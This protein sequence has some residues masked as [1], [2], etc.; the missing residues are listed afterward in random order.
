MRA[1]DAFC[2]MLGLSNKH[3]THILNSSPPG[4]DGRHFADDIF[5]RIFRK[6]KVLDSLIARFMGSHIGHMN[7]VMIKVSLKSV[8]KFTINDNPNFGLDN[9]LVPNRRQAIIWTN[10]DPIHGCIYAAPGG[11]ELSN[12]SQPARQYQTLR[13]RRNRHHFADDI[14]KC[15]FVILECKCLNFD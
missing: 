7:L 8:P 4:Q 3:F 10:A 2:V 14:F 9:G 5:I 1:A 11:E 13:P 6:W 15:I 12:T